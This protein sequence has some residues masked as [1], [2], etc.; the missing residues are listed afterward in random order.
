[1]LWD[2]AG[3]PWTILL[4]ITISSKLKK[5]KR[6]TF[7]C[8]TLYNLINCELTRCINWFVWSYYS[9]WFFP[10]PVMSTLVI[11]IYNFSGKNHW[12]CIRE[13]SKTRNKYHATMGWIL[14]VMVPYLHLLEIMFILYTM[15]FYICSSVSLSFNMKSEAILVFTFRLIF[16][17]IRGKFWT[18]V[19]L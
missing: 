7:S 13:T 3:F 2:V 8:I 19:F 6:L 11:C 5:R 1:M 18:I 4:R 12:S 16:L 17:K 15:F 10:E 14:L 9:Q